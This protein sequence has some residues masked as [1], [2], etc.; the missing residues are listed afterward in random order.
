MNEFTNRVLEYG[1]FNKR[2]LL[3]SFETFV[4]T[5]E[6]QEIFEICKGFDKDKWCFLLGNT[7][8]GKDHLAS[9]MARQLVDDGKIR[10]VYSGTSQQLMYKFRQIA[11]E[12]EGEMAALNFFGKVGLLILRDVGIRQ[13]TEKEK[14]AIIDILD[15]R[16]SNMKGIIIT[17]NIN[18]GEFSKTF[19]ERI[20]DRLYEMGIRHNNKPFLTCAWES[21]RKQL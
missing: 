13:F 18:A 20:T 15:Y 2:E 8:V 9:A 11:Y 10:S 17:G 7:G 6:K 5:P 3:Q 12:G 14:A 4:V 16:Y 1:N 21:W 19:D